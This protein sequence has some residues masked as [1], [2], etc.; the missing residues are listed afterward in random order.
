MNN[1]ETIMIINSNLDEAATKASIEKFTALINANGKVE[2]VE[3]IGKK[4]LAY[5][6]KKQ[7]EGY[8]VLVNFSSN[9]EF[10]DELDRVYNITDEVIKH[11]VVKKD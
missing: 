1:Y 8:Y 10:I 7:A 2:S 3:E 9:P 4:K 11:I 6:I 5:P